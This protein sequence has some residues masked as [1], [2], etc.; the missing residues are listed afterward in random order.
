VIC[1]LHTSTL[2]P[3]SE[4]ASYK[5]DKRLTI[6]L[7]SMVRKLVCGT[8]GT[9]IEWTCDTSDDDDLITVRGGARDD[10]ADYDKSILTK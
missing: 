4:T 8:V 5:G 9:Q 7:F 6:R 10:S 3:C 1:L 2:P